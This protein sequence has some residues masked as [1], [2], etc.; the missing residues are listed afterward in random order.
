M[1][2]FRKGNY[3]LLFATNIIARGIDIRSVGLVIN[4]DCPIK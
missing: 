1:L 2:E 4:L 3:D